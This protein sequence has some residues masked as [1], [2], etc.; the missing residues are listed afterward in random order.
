M[1]PILTEVLRGS[2]GESLPA[3]CLH[4]PSGGVVIGMVRVIAAIWANLDT[5]RG[6]FA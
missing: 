4:R 5:D 2:Q 1:H 3:P 6:V